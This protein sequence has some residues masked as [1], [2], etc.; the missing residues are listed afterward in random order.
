MLRTALCPR[1]VTAEEGP[2]SALWPVLRAGRCSGV[3]HLGLD[4]QL[5]HPAGDGAQLVPQ[6]L[7]GKAAFA[8]DGTRGG[9]HDG[10]SSPGPAEGLRQLPPTV[11]AG[12]GTSATRRL[13]EETGVPTGRWEMLA[14]DRDPHSPT[15][16][17]PATAETA[18]QEV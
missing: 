8:Q 9:V 12:E 11:P 10:S 16:G 14:A 7:W 2:W 13:G 5:S 1:G 4:G 17:D 15:P 18:R 6:A 3:E